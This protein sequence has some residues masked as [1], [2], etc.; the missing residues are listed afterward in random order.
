M[1]DHGEIQTF[2][3]SLELYTNLAGK[4]EVEWPTV[5]YYSG[6]TEA[7]HENPSFSTS[8]SPAETPTA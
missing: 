8:S 3:T 2:P 1:Q 7:I 4:R 5:R 6:G